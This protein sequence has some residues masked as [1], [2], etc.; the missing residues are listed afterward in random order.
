MIIES[1]GHSLEKIYPGCSGKKFLDHFILSRPEYISP[2]FAQLQSLGSQVIILRTNQSIQRVLR[3]QIEYLPNEEQILFIGSPWFDSIEEVTDSKLGLH[4]FAYHDPMIDLLLLLKTQ[5][6]ANSD[7]KHL[8]ET[9][10]KQRT[11]LK[12]LSKIA[13]DNINSV[14]IANEKGEI[15]WVNKSFT[16]VTGYQLEEV[17]GKKPGSFLQGPGTDQKTISYVRKQ[18]QSGESFYA[19]MLN[20]KKDKKP[21]WVRIQ[22][23]SIRN[24]H[25]ELTGFF[26]LEEDITEQKETAEKIADTERRFRLALEKIGD[27]VWEHDFRTGKTIFSKSENE[28][29]G[30]TTSE[31]TNNQKLWWEN[32]SKEDTHLLEENDLKYRNREIDSHNLEYRVIHKNGIIK[33]VLDRGVV[34]EKDELGNPLRVT[35]THTDITHIKQTEEELAQRVRQFQSLSE[36]IP[37][38]IYEFEF[39]EDGTDGFRYISPAIETIFNIKPADFAQYI[40]YIHPHDRARIIEKNEYCKKTLQPFYDESRLIYTGQGL[41]WIAIHSSFSYIE[42]N[43][44]KVFT[45]FL[46][47]ITERKNAEEALRTNEEK[48]RSIIANMNLGL[49]ELDINEDIT[50]A[51]QSFCDMSGYQ[52]EEL[53]GEKINDLLKINKNV[54]SES[55]KKSIQENE[56]VYEAAVLNK[57]GEEKWWLFSRAQRYDDKGTRVGYIGIHLDITEQKKLELDLIKARVHAE[58]LA[59]TKET[60]LANMSHE[61]RTPMNAIIG[62]SNQLGKTE[63]GPKQKFYLNTIHSSADSLMVILND[64][65]DL[66]KIEAGKLTLENIPFELKDTIKGAFQVLLHKAEEKGLMLTNTFYDERISPVLLGDPF[67]LN[68]VLL[69]LVS[70]GIKFTEKGSIDLVV[71]LLKEEGDTQIL[72][73]DVIDTGIGM[74]PSFV[75]QLFDKFSQENESITRK[76]GGTG[77]GMSISKE[78]VELMGGKIAVFSRKEIG[79]RVSISIGF[80]KAEIGELLITE[81][82]NVEANSLAGK[83]ILIVDDNKLNRLVAATILQNYGAEIREEDNGKLA[84]EAVERE[85]PDIILMDIQMPVMDG[86]EATE[87]LRK[88]GIQIP[89]IALTANAV[90]G[91]K[92]KCIFSGMNDYISKPFKEDEFMKI[93]FE[94]L[95]LKRGFSDKTGSVTVRK[96]EGL[97]DISGLYSISGGDKIFIKKMLL[98][99]CEMTPSMVSEMIEAYELNNMASMSAIAHKIIPSIDSLR[100]KQLQPVVRSIELYGKEGGRHPDLPGLLQKLK[101][102]SN[103]VVDLIKLQYLEK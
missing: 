48:Y 16:K 69:N 85:I 29:L 81:E 53:I 97:F 60:F 49:L 64:I 94:G 87:I 30:Y 27:Y 73:I 4:D 23:Q 90:K 6:I 26:A 54:L 61:I 33:W 44:S 82:S 19:E 50:F 37:G 15:N 58:K 45:G 3:G 100:I 20:Y 1:Y 31:L 78:I 80:K 59:Q 103:Q 75:H 55:G 43:G 63:L 41:K 46:M 93:I 40:N 25:N 35:G 95:A 79:T 39:R 5:E 65:L 86:Y 17:I 2:E 11:E 47:D 71:M 89:I 67:R 98:M 77:L 84:I 21:Y 34:I 102:L 10:N 62:M 74:E 24:K 99:F 18:I 92:E 68:Q 14:I 57:Y 51:N 22:G 9:V 83:K 101:E 96:K 56:D 36:N 72:G 38:V 32:V 52:L 91:E 8:V 42:K 13:E 76:Y 88:M 12:L 66:S 7:L 70:N 28:F